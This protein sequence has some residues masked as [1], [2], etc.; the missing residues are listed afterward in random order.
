VDPKLLE[1]FKA[2]ADNLPEGFK[3]S[4]GSIED[5]EPAVLEYSGERTP[6]ELKT[7]LDEFE[8]LDKSVRK[9]IKCSA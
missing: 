4:A 2:I 9:F 7:D 6:E 5:G 3:F 8:T 1:G